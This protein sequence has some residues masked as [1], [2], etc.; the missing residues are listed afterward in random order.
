LRTFF[1]KELKI[2]EFKLKKASFN[3]EL[4]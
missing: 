2:G 1:E 4:L 3:E